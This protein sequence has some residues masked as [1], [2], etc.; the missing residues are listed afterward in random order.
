MNL[1]MNQPKNETEDILLSITKNCETLI[2][3]THKK[4][5]E[6]L[7][8]KMKKSKQTFHFKPS[9]QIKADWIIGLTDVEVYIFNFNINATNNKFE[10]YRDS[11][12][13]FGFLELTNELEEILNISHNTQEHLEEI[14]GTRIIDDF[15]KL[16][17]EKKNSDSYMTTLVGYARSQFRDFEKYLRI[18]VGLDEEEIQLILK[19]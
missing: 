19:Q 16:S 2:Q 11:S 4:A 3:Q 8:F 6:A 18:V 9:T 14:I 1:N 17:T 10:L 13:N 7:E 15:I 12:Y 5:E